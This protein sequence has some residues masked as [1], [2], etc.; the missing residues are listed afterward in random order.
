MGLFV[1]FDFFGGPGWEKGPIRNCQMH[2]EKCMVKR[3]F[4]NKGLM[5]C[6]WPGGRRTCDERHNGGNF[7]KGRVIRGLVFSENVKCVIY[8]TEF[9]LM[10]LTDGQLELKLVQCSQCLTD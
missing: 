9:R 6:R 10:W 1:S 3:S 2:D 4:L 5:C 8:T 7:G